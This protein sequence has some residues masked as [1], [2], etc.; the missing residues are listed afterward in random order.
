MSS[1]LE[2]EIPL[3]KT[4]SGSL[5]TREQDFCWHSS[6]LT[7][8]ASLRSYITS[9]VEGQYLIPISD[10]ISNINQDISNLCTLASR[11]NWFR[12]IAIQGKWNE[13]H[14]FIWSGYTG[15]DIE[16]FYTEVRSIL[17]YVATILVNL[18]GKPKQI[19]GEDSFRKLSQWPEAKA[20]N[21]NKLGQE[22]SAII[23][24]GSWYSEIRRIRDNIIHLGS[25]TFVFGSPKD[26]ILFQVSKNFKNQINIGELMWNEYVVDFELYAGLYFARIL[27]LIEKLGDLIIG[28]IPKQY[29]SSS[30]MANY[31]GLDVY[32]TWINRLIEKIQ[33]A[34]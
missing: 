19:R 8:Y 15:L 34:G 29:I 24:S 16:H 3:L 11:I 1:I 18:T 7:C 4:I 2:S 12:S 30:V 17:D 9:T 25:N 6:F 28:K 31:D 5:Y 20:D 27:A 13:R 33:Q 23:R 10:P 21:E 26:G 22:I 14:P 32:G